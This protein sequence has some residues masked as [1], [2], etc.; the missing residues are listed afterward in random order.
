MDLAM[1]LAVDLAMDLAMDFTMELI[2]DLTFRLFSQYHV[3]HLL[4][5]GYLGEGGSITGHC[6]WREEREEEGGRWKVEG[7]RWRL[8]RSNCRSITL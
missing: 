8:S 2:L 3:S 7:G 1:D 6:V 4:H 5:V